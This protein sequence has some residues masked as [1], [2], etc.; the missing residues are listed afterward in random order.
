MKVG[1]IV[2]LADIGEGSDGYRYPTFPEI[3]ETARRI[4]DAGFDSLWI[5]DHLLYREVDGTETGIWE[6]WT[7]LS[8]LAA[9]TDR[10]TLGPLVACTHFRNPALLAKMAAT[11]DEVS[12]GRL[13]LGLGA[14]WNEPEFEAFGIPFDHRLERF[15]EAVQII[16]PMLRTGR[17]DFE[18]RYYRARNADLLPRGP[19]PEGPPILIGGWGPKMLELTTEYA[20]LW[21][22]GYSGPIDTFRPHLHRF[23]E[24][25]SRAGASAAHIQTSALLK[26]GW[27]DLA[28]VPSFFE[29]EYITG[30]PPEIARSFKDYANAGVDH[31]MC[32]Y[33]PY[34][35]EA[36]DRLIDALRIYRAL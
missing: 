27:P 26:L 30:S 29:G 12:N 10:L 32:Q 33:H 31:I 11:L 25:R 4:E 22:G 3:R 8:A 14:G 35:T 36:L 6:G 19:R 7:M 34:T 2:R 13:I 24:A 18:G 5:F 16:V 21:N 23:N 15:K 9:V 1:A 20:D 17:V 28:E